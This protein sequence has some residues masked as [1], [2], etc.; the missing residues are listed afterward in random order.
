VD[1]DKW[2]FVIAAIPAY[3]EEKNIAKVVL[4][5]SRYVD[6]VVVCDDGS[7]DMTA[8]IAEELGADVVRHERNM[9]YGAAIQSLFRR[10]RELDAGVMVTLDGD[11]QHDPREISA[12]VKPILEGEADVVL[13]SRFLEKAKAREVPFYRRMGIKALTRLT[14][15][16]SN[17]GLRDAQSGFRAYGRKAIEGLRL[18]EA[19]M[20]ASVE[21]LLRAGELGLRVVEV[22]VGCVYRGLENTSKHG[23]LRHGGSVAMSILRLVVE[24]R[25]LLFLGVPGVVSLLVGVL[26]GVWMLQLYA[27]ERKIITNIALASTAFILIGF[28]AVSTAITL[29]AVT[30]LTQKMEK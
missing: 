8:D 10:C 9:G 12:L 1:K 21:I 24:R 11:G 6:R 13:G 30:R 23:A 20:G 2:P 28:F 14:D 22:P 4:Q 3:N 16:A 25:P 15:A 19:G 26:F 29:Y 27:I 7:V 18:F 17:Y 5:A